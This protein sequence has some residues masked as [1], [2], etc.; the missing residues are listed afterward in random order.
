MVRRIYEVM[1]KFTKSLIAWL[2]VLLALSVT[3]MQTEKFGQ[4]PWQSYTFVVFQLPLHMLVLFGC[5]SLCAIGYHLITLG[6]FC[7]SF[8][9]EENRKKVQILTFLWWFV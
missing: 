5:Y 9:R 8:S 4:N 1:G 6:K 7:L 3:E 2:L